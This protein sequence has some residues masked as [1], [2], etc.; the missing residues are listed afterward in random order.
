MSPPIRYS[1]RAIS[2]RFVRRVHVDVHRAVALGLV[3]DYV[4][5]MRMRVEVAFVSG[6]T[7]LRDSKNPGGGVLVLPAGGWHAFHTSVSR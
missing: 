2:T 1:P 7:A 5:S 3:T 4:P 6:G